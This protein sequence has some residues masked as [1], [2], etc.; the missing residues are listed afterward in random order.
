MC[1]EGE[2]VGKYYI[3]AIDLDRDA[4]LIEDTAGQKSDIAF[5]FAGIPRD[6]PFSIIRITG[7]NKAAAETEQNAEISSALVSSASDIVPEPV[8]G[9]FVEDEVDVPLSEAGEAAEANEAASVTAAAIEA[10]PR[11]KIEFL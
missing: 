8:E 10:K 11:F 9:N 1:S 4:I 7:F 3:R 5:E 2:L 6:A